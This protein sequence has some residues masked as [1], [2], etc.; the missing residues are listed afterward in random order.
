MK[1]TIERFFVKSLIVMVTALFLVGTVPSFGVGGI[2]EAS[3]N[4]GDIGDISFNTYAIENDGSSE[5]Q[6]LPAVKVNEDEVPKIDGTSAVIMDMGNG[7]ILYEKN[8]DKVR[9]PASL[10]KVLTALV[11]LEE[12]DLDEVVTVQ[13]NVEIEGSTVGIVPGERLTVEQLLYGMMLESGNDAAEALAIACDGGIGEFADHMNERAAQCGAENSTFRNPNGLNEDQS[14][15]NKTTA[16][17]MA[18]ISAEAMENETFRKIVSTTKYKIPKTNKSEEREL[19]NSNLCLWDKKTKVKIKGKEVPLKYEGCNGIKTGMTSDAGYCFIGNAQQDGTTFMA[20][21]MN[22]TDDT[23]RFKDVIKLWDFAFERFGA[24]KLISEG[25]QVG[26]QRVDHGAV[27]KVPI[28]CKSDLTITIEKD[29]SD[30]PGITAELMLDEEKLQAPIEKDQAV[31]RVLAIDSGG[32]LVGEKTVYTTEAVAVG[33][34][35]SYVGIEDR[36]APWVAGAAAL[37]LLIIIITAIAKGHGRRKQ[38]RQKQEDMKTQLVNMRT[39]GEG[40]TPVEWSELVGD[41]REV[42][43]PEGPARLTED[44]FEELNAPEITRST[45]PK[46]KAELRPEVDPNRPR[47]HGRL[48]KEELDDLLAGKMIGTDN[49][50]K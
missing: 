1:A 29:S 48:T 21:S 31:G 19:I 40:M 17:D 27:R 20:I 18:L 47:R 35:L 45:R 22:S 49:D 7:S 12:M 6:I 44:E 34:P 43:I 39:A 26:V 8:A 15:L 46:P 9:E 30:D 41:P 42:P 4:V 10:T 16:R 24:Y 5:T 11:V 28:T 14:R 50:R 13:E 33:G 37:L 38:K 32:R 3:F 23:S 2:G 25:D 36:E